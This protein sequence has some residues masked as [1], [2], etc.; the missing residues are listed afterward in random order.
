M[1]KVHNF[2]VMVTFMRGTGKMIEEKEE[3]Y[4]ILIGQ[5]SEVIDMKENFRTII[6]KEKEYTIIKVEISMKGIIKMM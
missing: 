1:E 5:N 4:I 2:G 3:V 6:K